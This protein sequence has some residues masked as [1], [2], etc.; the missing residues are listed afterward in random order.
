MSKKA[1]EALDANQADS[2]AKIFGETLAA[3]LGTDGSHYYHS[4]FQHAARHV[5]SP[6]LRPNKDTPRVLMQFLAE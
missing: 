3:A 5:L 2:K 1:A 4:D 6:P